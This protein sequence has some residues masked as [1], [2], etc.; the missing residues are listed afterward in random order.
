MRWMLRLLCPLLCVACLAQGA[1]PFRPQLEPGE[2]LAVA[3]PEGNIQLFGEASKEA[4]MGSLA[5]LVWLRLEG[6]DWASLDVTYRCTGTAGPYH[7]WQPS[8]HGK[9]DL[10]KATQESCNLA[11]LA[12]A[13][14]SVE[15]WRRGYG[16]GAGRARLE[17]AFAPFLGNR[18]PAGENIPEMTPVLDR[19]RR[20]AADQPGGHGALAEGSEPGA[21]PGPARRLL[22]GTFTSTFRTDV[23]W[24]KTGTAP[25]PLRSRDHQ[26]LVA[27]ATTT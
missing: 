3:D 24:M 18:L 13:Q 9:V 16:E 12:W 20:S 11:Y 25:R 14:M 15:R 8:G 23:W 19:G 27:G 22:L 7:C 10:A 4:P 2:G 5:K 21:A 6:D 26:R 17:E 1:K